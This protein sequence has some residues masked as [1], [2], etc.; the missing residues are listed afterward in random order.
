MMGE[1][2]AFNFQL[3]KNFISKLVF[4]VKNF[5]NSLISVD[6][7]FIQDN[8]LNKKTFNLF[9]D[10]AALECLHIIRLF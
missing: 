10:K 4:F 3:R 7:K 8:L 9:T 5:F 2:L 6:L 1:K